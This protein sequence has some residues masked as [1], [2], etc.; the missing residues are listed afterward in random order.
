MNK[1]ARHADRCKI[2][3][4]FIPLNTNTTRTAKLE[5]VAGG[6]FWEN[7][8]GGLQPVVVLVVIGNFGF[9]NKEQVNVIGSG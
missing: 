8:V 5:I 4:V 9:K 6:F 2:N 1:L 3:R 7:F